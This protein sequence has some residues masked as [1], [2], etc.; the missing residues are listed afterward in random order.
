MNTDAAILD[1]LCSKS[2]D[3]AGH[4]RYIYDLAIA[5]KAQRLVEVGVWTG[6]S[7][8][9]LL[10][11][12]KATGGRLISVDVKDYPDTRAQIETLGL[13][14]W[15]IFRIADSLEYERNWY[16]EE[17]LILID[18]CHAAGHTE[19]EFIAYGAHV[20]PGGVMLCHD[21]T[22]P[23][24]AANLSAAA[25]ALKTA[26]P[27]RWRTEEFFTHCNGLAVLRKAK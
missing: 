18:S 3:I 1:A 5:E 6:Q 19:A 20:K 25:S 17:D 13:S 4:L 14:P 21:V 2:S 23:E 10:L 7:T 12:A 26:Q 22:A 27:G 11:A 8:M 9:A 24:W 16:S 15:W